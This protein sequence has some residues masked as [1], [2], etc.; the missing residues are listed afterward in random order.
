MSGAEPRSGGR[1]SGPPPGTW[2]PLVA[3]WELVTRPLG[4]VIAFEAASGLL[5]IAAAVV[6]LLWANSSI[7]NSYRA[8][9]HATVG[10]RLSSFAFE[11]SLEW[12][13]NDVLMAIFFFVVGIEIRKELHDGQLAKWRRAALPVVAA[14][15]GMAVPASFYLALS[16]SPEA[17]RGWGI[18]M[19]TDIAF[20]LG[21][22]SLL[23]KRVPPALRVLL[24]ALAVI[25]DLGAIVVIAIFY[26]SGI[27]LSGVAFATVGLLMILALRAI[28][29]RRVPI[30]VLP[31]VLVWAGVY[32][33]GVHPTIAGVLI[34]LLTPVQAW[35]GV[36]RESPADRLLHT[37][38]PWV[39]YAIMPI[40][41]L[42]NAGVNLSGLSLGGNGARVST[43]IVVSLLAGKPIGVVLSSALALWTKF[44]ALPDGLGRRHLVVLGVVAGIGF[45]MSLFVAQL[46]F[47][48]PAL[49]SAAKLGV[50]IAS[51]VAMILG[52]IFGRLLLPLRES[53]EP[54][55]E[56]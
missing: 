56:R 55:T 28:G 49:L 22:L 35:Q 39:S 37:L 7:A 44:A 38:H 30:Y 12:F 34:G 1:A 47:S 24:L 45:T 29:V 20:A 16:R 25:D 48:D 54:E 18:P 8:L 33:A 9:W 50:L 3:I 40:F 26:S 36:E 43:A 21:V 32:A 17:Y 31:G 4:R 42:A 23:G 11:R 27:A 46:A 5:L 51:A 10:V 6:A 53:L 19:A 2:R 15:G 41:A 52:L 13:V 14:L